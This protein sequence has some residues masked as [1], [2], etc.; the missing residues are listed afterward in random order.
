VRGQGLSAQVRAIAAAQT[1]AP[2]EVVQHSSVEVQFELTLQ[3]EIQFNGSV[4]SV[5]AG[6]FPDPIAPSG[7]PPE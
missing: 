5:A 7:D 4:I 6:H 2:Q 3:L 1:N